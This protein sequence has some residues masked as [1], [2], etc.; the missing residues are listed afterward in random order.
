MR[1]VDILPENLALDDEWNSTDIANF[2]DFSTSEEEVGAVEKVLGRR[3]RVTGIQYLVVG[4]GS[5]IDNA[6]WLPLQSLPNNVATAALLHSFD[7]A[8]TNFED[9]IEDDMTDGSLTDEAQIDLDVQEAMD[10][11]RDD[12]DLEE[13]RKACMTDDQIARLLSKQ[14]ELGLGSRNLILFDGAD[15]GAFGASGLD[16]NDFKSFYNAGRSHKIKKR[17]EGSSAIATISPRLV[18]PD[19]Y[20]GFDVMDFNRASLRK[21]QKGKG[22]NIDFQLSDSEME[23]SLEAAWQKDRSKKRVRK[24]ARA[25]LRAQGLLGKKK[26]HRPDL[27]A[28][29]SDGITFDQIK[30]EIAH[31]LN[32]PMESLSLPPM[33]ASARKIVHE[34][35]HKLALKTRSMG[36]GITRFPILYKTSK[37][38]KF[39]DGAFAH[40]GRKFM[41]RLG[42]RKKHR[43]QGAIARGRSGPGAVY[44]DG[45]EVG[46]SAPELSVENKGRAMLEK[47]GW[48]SG[49][50]LGAPNN[51]GISE[52]I[53]QIVRT[54]RAGLG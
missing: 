38:R 1:K 53:A 26:D 40:I 8:S 52:P 44:R 18:G 22:A 3:E 36:S 34:V 14:E 23:R 17:A 15:E 6:R 39:D 19:P 41:P 12:E 50:A 28:K 46:G 31:F 27:K 16:K 54:T 35:G 13:R 42:Q 43:G 9:G 29:Y 48:S 2:E 32:S 45:E 4:V 30:V 5:G 11:S 10:E 25:E 7:T 24:E 21:R 33:D 20:D 47:M 51:Q 49:K 37:T